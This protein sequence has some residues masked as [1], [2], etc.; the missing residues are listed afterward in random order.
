MCHYVDHAFAY[1]DKHHFC[2]YFSPKIYK[3]EGEN[4]WW[5]QYWKKHRKLT[6]KY[7]KL[8]VNKL[9]AF[10]QFV[11]PKLVSHVSGE[12]RFLNDADQDCFL[13]NDH[14]TS[15]RLTTI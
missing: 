7:V 9:F 3:I 6:K 2:G 11:L 4:I 13:S 5:G 1:K 14:T 15:L 10:E 12:V 8:A